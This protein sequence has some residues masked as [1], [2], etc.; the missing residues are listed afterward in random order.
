M[1]GRYK[2]VWLFLTVT[3]LGAQPAQN[4]NKQSLA[5]EARAHLETRPDY[6]F[7]LAKKAQEYGRLNSLPH[8]QAEGNLLLGKLFSNQSAYNQALAHLLNCLEL[9]ET[10][11]HPSLQAEAYNELGK[12]YHFLRRHEKVLPTHQQAVRLYQMLEDTAGLAETYGYIGHY[13]E[14]QGNYDSAAALQQRALAILPTNDYPALAAKIFSHVG[15]IY[16]DLQDYPA[17]EDYFLQ[18][19]ALNDS[20]QH[21]GQRIALL[22]NLGD[23]TFQQKRYLEAE[24]WLLRALTLA[25]IKLDNYQIRSA[26]RD[27]GQLYAAQ[28]QYDRAYTFLD[29][30]VTY[31]KKIYS[32]DGL[33]Q[34]ANLEA[35]FEAEKKEREIRLLEKDRKINR[36]IISLILAGMIS[37]IVIGGLLVH[38]QRSQMRQKQVLF[39]AQ[40]KYMK[41]QLENKSRSLNNYSLH[42]IE[43][44]QFLQQLQAQLITLSRPEAT[45]PKRKLHSLSQDIDTNL[46]PE[47]GWENFRQ[48]FEA[49]YPDFFR[50]LSQQNARLTHADLKLA[51]LMKMHFESKEIAGILGISTDSLR[52]ARYR[53]RKK[54]ALDKKTQLAAFLHS[55]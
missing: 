31:F 41:A 53:L 38:R 52:V 46:S 32:E 44:N 34:A 21:P 37:S 3:L 16:E 2:L 20:V 23:V 9:L 55:L 1:R 39:A 28:G 12:L 15:S 4:P 10:L 19:L 6:A 13:Y 50:L 8:L 48:T 40:E 24:G 36:L 25:Q 22:N 49:A 17:A 54:L 42:L 43:K 45:P 30:S 47:K 51:A 14:K 33:K 29:S 26:L 35:F 27:L 11:D 18:S 5:Q 7:E